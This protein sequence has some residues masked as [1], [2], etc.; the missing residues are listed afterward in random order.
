MKFDKSP[1]WLK[2]LFGALQSEAGGAPRQMFGYPCAF[3]NGQ[4][5]TGL[6]AEGLFVRLA[7]GD[8]DKLLAREGAH[9]FEPMK[10]RPM[11][12]YVVVPPSMLEDEEELLQ[13][14]KKGR[15][16]AAALPPKKA[17]A[18][19]KAAAARKKAPA[20]RKR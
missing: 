13:W 20:G 9:R 15:A 1:Q 2:T 19:K 7:E 16:Y 8:R 3:E 5:F 4:L 12:E 18:G 11:R 14:M 17:A 10:G 6:F